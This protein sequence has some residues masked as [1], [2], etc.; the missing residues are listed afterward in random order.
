MR[1]ERLAK[2]Y[3]CKYKVAVNSADVE[4]SLRHKIDSLYTVVSKTHNV[5]RACAESEAANPATPEEKLAVAGH[6]FCKHLVSIIDYLKA[7]Q[8]KISLSDLKKAVEAI[9]MAVE[10]NL[11]PQFGEDG[12]PSEDAL[13][14]STQ[15]P[16]VS[17][18]IS[19]MVPSGR[20]HDRK[21]RD[22][23]FGK[24]KKGLSR[25]MSIISDMMNDLRQLGG[26]AG[27][28]VSSRF[29]PEKAPLA[30]SD[31]LNFIRQYGDS[32]GI[33][34]Q[35]D[36]GT[37]FRNDPQLRADMTPII[38]ALIRGRFPKDDASVRMQIAEIVKNYEERKS[39]NAP[40]FEESA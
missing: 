4:S 2:L 29:E 11:N 37:A 19:M 20:K 21:L 40:L 14:S 16:H 25:I 34:S 27:P 23:Q 38:N 8:K 17:A 26:V 35:E 13:P 33:S 5:L 22:E 30:E 12:T 36:W 18:L 9:K 28:E 7:N 24:A 31:I 6:K 32:Y 15:F 39:T 10:T 1:L 3:A